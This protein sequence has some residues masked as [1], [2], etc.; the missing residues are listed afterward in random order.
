MPYFFKCLYSLVERHQS[1]IMTTSEV[2]HFLA[3][4][5]PTQSNL[6][7]PAN[8]HLIHCRDLVPLSLLE[9]TFD[10]MSRGSSA[11]PR[12]RNPAVHGKCGWQKQRTCKDPKEDGNFP[13]AKIIEA[14][15]PHMNPC[16][17]IVLPSTVQLSHS[18]RDT[19]GMW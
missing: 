4:C 14:D 15:K 5:L 2:L 10:N 17:Y 9:Q 12:L 18:L 1:F 11:Q 3:F 8:S 19:W 6:E 7:L 16:N 13:R